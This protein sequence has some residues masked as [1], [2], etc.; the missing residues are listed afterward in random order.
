MKRLA[1]L[2]AL[3]IAYAFLYLPFPDAADACIEEG[4]GSAVLK[5]LAAVLVGGVFMYNHFRNRINTF[6]NK[7]FSREEKPEGAEDQG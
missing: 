1:R 2:T 7:L 5:V 3:P 6:V 4:I